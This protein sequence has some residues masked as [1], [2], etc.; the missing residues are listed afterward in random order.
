MFLTAQGCARKIAMQ[1]ILAIAAGGAV[2]AVLRHFSNNSI[3][4]LL[5]TSFPFGILLINIIGSFL[6]GCAVSAFA[7]GWDLSQHMKIFLT[8]G[9]LG[10]FTTFSAFS[11]DVINLIEKHAYMSAGIYV[12]ASVVVSVIALVAGMLIVRQVMT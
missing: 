8:V 1:T 12:F 10:G 9:L 3:A 6:M 2:G 4:L 11:L 7:Y 5:G